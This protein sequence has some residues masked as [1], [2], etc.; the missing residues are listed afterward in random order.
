MHRLPALTRLSLLFGLLCSVAPGAWSQ[1]VAMTGSM[2]SKALLVVNGSA[3]KAVAAGD[4]FQGVKVIS[5]GAGEAMIEVGGKRSNVS[6]GG[7]PVNFKGSAGGNGGATQIVLT[8]GDHGHFFATG[9]INGSSAQFL[10]DTGAST[11][12]IGVNDAE[13]MGLK[14]KDAKPVQMGTANGTAI[15]YL[16]TLNSVRVQDVE[17]YNVEAVVM[18]QPM[19]NVLLGNSFLTRFQMKRENDKLT[20]DRRF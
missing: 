17:I 19:P 15:G 12:A 4:T 11:V 2:G 14:I 13:R 16:I 5:V 10:V 6:M 18:P 7:A 3:P 8:A 20:L 9:S 1:S